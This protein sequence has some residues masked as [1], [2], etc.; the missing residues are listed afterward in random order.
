M[1]NVAY[2][3][4]ANPQVYALSQAILAPG[5]RGLVRRLVEELLRDSPAPEPVLDVGC[6]P[7]SV[8]QEVG[9]SPLGLDLSF[10]YVEAYNGDGL[11]GVAGSASAIPFVDQSF[12]L[13]WSLGLL[14]HLGDAEFTRA[15]TEMLR[16]TRP[17]GRILILDAVYP[18]SFWANPLAH[19][20]R[21]ADRGEFVR[22]QSHFESLLRPIGTFRVQRALY[23]L[24]GLEIVVADLQR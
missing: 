9:C 23:A 3:I 5:S 12:G 2:A 16:V 15:V 18:T 8:L 20:I 22:T 17:G 10:D 4:L 6:G 14:H 21:K 11:R 19:G 1:R 13:V 24:N 7:A